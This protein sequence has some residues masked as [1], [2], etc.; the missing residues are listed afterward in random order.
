VQSLDARIAQARESQNTA[1]LK[2]LLRMFASLGIYGD[3]FERPLL[4]QTDTFY[5]AESTRRLEQCEARSV[6]GTGARGRGARN[7]RMRSRSQPP[8]PPNLA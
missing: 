7:R 5:G 4:E 8:P 2:A 1:L 3:A 6:P